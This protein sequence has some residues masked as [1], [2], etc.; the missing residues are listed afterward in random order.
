M[1]G[2]IVFGFMVLFVLNKG[3]YFVTQDDASSPGD[4]VVADNPGGGSSYFF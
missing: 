1:E 2:N 4:L 3:I